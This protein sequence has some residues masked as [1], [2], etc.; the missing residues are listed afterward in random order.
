ML[1]FAACYVMKISCGKSKILVNSLPRPSTNIWMKGKMLEGVDQFKCLRARPLKTNVTREWLAYHTGSIKQTNM[2]GNMSLSSLDRRSFYCQPSSI[3]SCHG[4]AMSRHD[5]L[6]KIV[7]QRIV[8]GSRRRERHR[9]SWKDNI[10]KWT[11]KSMSSLLRMTEVDG[12]SPQRMHLSEY[13]S[14]A[15]A[16]R[17]L[18]S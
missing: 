11:G 5:A 2:Y 7:P 12:Q 15:W 16:S 13:P 3:G 10:K 17:V 4:S 8:D 9:E 18:V 14:D 1:N 6:P